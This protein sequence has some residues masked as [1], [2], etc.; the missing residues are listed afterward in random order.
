MLTDVVT[1]DKLDPA[2]VAVNRY[3]PGPSNV[4]FVF[5]A[6]FVPLVEKLTEAG[7]LADQVYVSE[8]SPPPPE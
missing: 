5:F 6:E 3:V 8:L 1:A 4:A 2:I 7:P